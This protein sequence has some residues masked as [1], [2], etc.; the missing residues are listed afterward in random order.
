MGSRSPPERSDRSATNKSVGIKVNL[1][2]EATQASPS[3]NGKAHTAIEKKKTYK[4]ENF[5]RKIERPPSV[6]TVLA[7][8]YRPTPSSN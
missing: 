6:H 5:K 7:L 8:W 1:E 4:E 3:L 2:G